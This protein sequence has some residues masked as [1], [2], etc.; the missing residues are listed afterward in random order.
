LLRRGS[1]G[2][3]P[4]LGADCKRRFQYAGWK[5]RCPK[6]WLG[7][8]HVPLSL[9]HEKFAALAFHPGAG[10]EVATGVVFLTSHALHFE[11]EG[12]ALE[13]P[14]ARLM[15]EVREG[16][17]ERITFTDPAQP[18]LEIFTA[19]LELL[20]S[21][22]TPALLRAREGLEARLSRREIKRR[23]KL[24]AYCI[25]AG[26][27]LTWLGSVALS[28][29][30]RSIVA[31]IPP[32]LDAKLGTGLME[33][34][35]QVEKFSSDSNAVARLAEMSEPLLRVLPPTANGYQF[36]ILEDDDPNAFALPG[37]HIVVHTGLLEL[38]DRSEELLGVIAHE[39]AHVTERHHY[40]KQ[41]STAGPLVV[42]AVFLGG[43]GGAGSLLGGGAA[44]LVGAG[45]SQEYETEADDQAW[46]YLVTAN[47]DPRGMADMFRKMKL[48]PAVA[49]SEDLVPRAF[50]SH[51]ALEKR[52]RRLDAKWARLKHKAGFIQLKQ[53]QIL[54]R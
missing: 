38:T 13:I 22:T 6:S 41:I 21:P 4:Q 17:E 12:C 1:G 45:F 39:V 40:R 24:I 7:V 54:K 28:L 29:M 11:A 51:P 31:R 16:D 48:H 43:R 47:I 36:H 14:V 5:N 3:F 42:C 49:Q 23:L 25:L 46:N 18:G 26:V 34:I 32:E 9:L 50:S 33:E 30:V 37:G 10:N 20:E 27:L 19:D 8:E 2:I 52:I 35:G 15:A 53:E 44:L